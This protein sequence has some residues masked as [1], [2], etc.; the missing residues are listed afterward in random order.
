MPRVIG[1]EGY[2]VKHII[3]FIKL[4]RFIR[5]IRAPILYKALIEAGIM[6]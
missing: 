5:L 1:L 4:I 6:I 2:K 3:R